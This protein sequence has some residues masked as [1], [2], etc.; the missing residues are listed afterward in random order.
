MQKF[1]SS[2]GLDQQKSSSDE[3][4]NPQNFAL[5]CSHNQFWKHFA[6]AVTRWD[7]F[8]YSLVGAF[9]LDRIKSSMEKL[10]I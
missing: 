1:P 7:K 3:L 9:G 6:S 4:V 10:Q 8:E 2:L 5:E